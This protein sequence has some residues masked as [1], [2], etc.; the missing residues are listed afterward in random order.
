[1]AF[2]LLMSLNVDAQF[3]KTWDFSKGYSA[4]TKANLNADP[5][6]VSN[7]TDANTGETTGWKDNAKMSGELMANG[8]VIEEFRGINF[9]TSG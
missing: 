9:Y 2:S 1:M 6:W 5:N 3:R 8:V 4:E 7:R